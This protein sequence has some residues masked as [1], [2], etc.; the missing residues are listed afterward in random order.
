MS[1]LLRRDH[2]WLIL[3]GAKVSDKIGRHQGAN[4]KKPSV[5]LIGGAMAYTFYRALGIPT[6]ASRVEGGQ[7]TSRGGVVATRPAKGNQI[8]VAGR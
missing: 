8:F 1:W 5:F 4:G 6:G 3:G 2:S 7:S